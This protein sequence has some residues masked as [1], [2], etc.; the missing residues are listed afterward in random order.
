MKIAKIA[1]VDNPTVVLRPRS[2]ELPQISAYT[3]YFRKVVSLAY[4]FA[5][6]SMGLSS[7]LRAP[8]DASLLPQSA[9]RTF[10]VI[11]GR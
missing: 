5:A 8:K 1:V 4:I 2:D 7:F 9:Y 10:K 3:L 6:G 11:Q